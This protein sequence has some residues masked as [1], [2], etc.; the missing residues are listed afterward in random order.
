MTTDEFVH[1]M[2]TDPEYAKVIIKERFDVFVTQIRSEYSDF[3]I[4]L[5]AYE[6]PTSLEM[7]INVKRKKEIDVS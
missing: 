3:Y 4:D 7:N 6:G 2:K 1:A 5:R